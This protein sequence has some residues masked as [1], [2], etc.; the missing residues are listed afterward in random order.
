M[1]NLSLLLLEDYS[2]FRQSTLPYKDWK[3]IEP[4]NCF[5]YTNWEINTKES[6]A[7]VPSRPKSISGED[8]SIIESAAIS[9]KIQSDRQ[10][11]KICR[12]KYNQ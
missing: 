5:P 7:D 1:R 6:V 12:I 9:V 10:L 8:E 11:K 2:T 4:H 3:S